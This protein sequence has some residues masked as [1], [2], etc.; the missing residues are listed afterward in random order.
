MEVI[1]F[2]ATVEVSFRFVPELVKEQ[3]NSR[4]LQMPFQ[5]FGKCNNGAAKVQGEPNAI[6]LSDGEKEK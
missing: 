5:N 2:L 4:M 6:F 3:E 1:T